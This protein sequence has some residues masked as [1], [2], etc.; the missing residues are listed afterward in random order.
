MEF[1]LEILVYIF[2]DVLVKEFLHDSVM[3]KLLFLKSY[4]YH[5]NQFCLNFKATRKESRK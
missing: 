5:K 4:L 1:I 3:M 2:L